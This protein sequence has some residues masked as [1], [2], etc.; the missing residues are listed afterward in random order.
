MAVEY[1]CSNSSYSGSHYTPG[2]ICFQQLPICDIIY[3]TRFKNVSAWISKPEIEEFISIV[4]NARYI[5]KPLTILR[6]QE[7]FDKAVEEMKLTASIKQYNINIKDAICFYLKKEDFISRHHWLTL[8]SALRYI[9]ERSEV[10]VAKAVVENYRKYG[11]ICSPF[12]HLILGHYYGKGT[13]T[14]HALI[15][16]AF[17]NVPPKINPEWFRISV[18]GSLEAL[19]KVAPNKIDPHSLIPLHNYFHD[20]HILEFT[21][22]TPLPELIELL[23]L[24]KPYKN[25]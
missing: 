8:L 17:L 20:D 12:Q 6:T 16:S 21:K 19:F 15:N 5:N 25:V 24:H 13:N 4:D 2:A 10:L 18:W 1:V 3:V 23:Q 9:G 14:N 11:D 22:R 7:E